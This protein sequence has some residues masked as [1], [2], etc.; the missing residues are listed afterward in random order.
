MARLAQEEVEARL[1]RLE[2][3]TVEGEA[4]AKDFGMG[5]F[6]GSVELVNRLLPIA[7]ELNHHPDLSISWGTVRVT[8][9]THSEGGLT[10]SDFALA[11]QIDALTA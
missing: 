5:D 11:Q 4:I 1:A 2:G 10:A 9:T 6:A 7:E 8:I 3:W